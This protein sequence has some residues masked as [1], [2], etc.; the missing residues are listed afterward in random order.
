MLMNTEDQTVDMLHWKEFDCLH[1]DLLL[2]LL[3]MRN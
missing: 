1:G 3:K 2:P